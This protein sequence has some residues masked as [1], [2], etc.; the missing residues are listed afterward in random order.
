MIVL[1]DAQLSPS[2]ARWLASRFGLEAISVRDLGLGESPDRQIFTA[3]RLMGAVV[4]TKDRDFV[5]MV[6]RLG[7]PPQVLRITSGNASNQE[8]RRALGPLIP[9]AIERLA[10]GEPLVEIG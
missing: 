6:E 5:D 10:A 8:L 7:S 9:H 2:I 1:V 3:A 4:M